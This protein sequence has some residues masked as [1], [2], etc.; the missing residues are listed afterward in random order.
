MMRS[1]VAAVLAAI[2]L[3]AVAGPAAAHAVLVDTAPPD[4]AVLD[5]AP[6]DLVLNFNEA[7]TPV[8]MRMVGPGGMQVTLPA[9]AAAGAVRAALPADLPAGSYLVSWRVISADAHPIGGAFVFSVGGPAGA[10]VAP[11]EGASRGE[12]W[13]RIAV[14]ANRALGDAALMFAAGG[15]LCMVLVFGG[16]VPR[17][18]RAALTAGAAIAMLSGVVAVA[19]ARGWIAA[20][21]LAA[22]LDPAMWSFDATAP[23]RNRVVAGL[24]GLAAVVIGLRLMPRRVGAALAVGGALVACAGV[25]LSGHVVASDAG[26]PAQ[27]ALMVHAVTAAFWLGSLWPLWVVMCDA[28]AGEALLRLRRFSAIAVPAVGLLVLAGIGVV[29]SRIAD[30]DA[31]LSTGYG[32]MLLLKL[33]FVAAMIALALRNRRLTKRLAAMDKRSATALTGSIRLE[34]GCAGAVL[35]LTAMLGHTAPSAAQ[36]PREVAS[37]AV[38]EAPGVRLRIALEPGRIG[39][40]R[41]IADLTGPAGETIAAREVTVALSL[42]EQAIEPLERTA[43]AEQGRFIADD[44]HMPLSGRWHVRVDALVGDFDKLSF[45]AEIAVR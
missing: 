45:F 19:L 1:A 17:R 39:V 36:A 29:L 20:A 25:A 15:A 43:R 6:S 12:A 3:L 9:S 18:L 38:A 13:W 14:I 22:L 40:N 42:P 21:P 7:V 34:I 35:L 31:L 23:L 2:V 11:A 33:V 37:V 44:I 26:W 28:T 16:A 30:V 41:L 4:R 32:R 8:A 24:L 5:R 10:P 27:A